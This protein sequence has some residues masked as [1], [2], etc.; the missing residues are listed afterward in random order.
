[1]LAGPICQV[2]AD[3]RFHQVRKDGAMT[4]IAMDAGT[5]R[6][7]D[8]F[9]KAFAIYGRRFVP[10]TIL[11]VIA[12]IPDYIVVITLTTRPE[13]GPANSPGRRRF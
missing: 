9:S 5:F 4:D 2:H 10:F 11:T 1:M 6:L 7:A 12:S 8:V 3:Q 13:A